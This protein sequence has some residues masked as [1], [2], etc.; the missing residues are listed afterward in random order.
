MDI[1]WTL[2]I[3]AM[4]AATPPS[5]IGW[6]AHRE[7]KRAKDISEKTDKAVNL[8]EIRID[9]RMDELLDL[10]RKE[11]AATATLEEKASERVRKDIE[12]D[13]RTGS[14]TPLPLGRKDDI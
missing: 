11:A 7:A 9:G 6:F 14:G 10:N 8:L 13:S 5:I 1:N 12:R 2:I 3:V 4:I